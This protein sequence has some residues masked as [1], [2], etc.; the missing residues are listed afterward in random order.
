MFW[1]RQL[2]IRSVFLNRDCFCFDGHILVMEIRAYLSEERLYVSHIFLQVLPTIRQKDSD[3]VE[4]QYL[5]TPS[6][7]LFEDSDETFAKLKSFAGTLQPFEKKINYTFKN[8]AYLLQAF[9]HAS[10]FYNDI[11]GSTILIHID[12]I[13]MVLNVFLIILWF[14]QIV[15]SGSNFLATPFW[16]F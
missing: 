3:K 10:Y 8:K 1:S 9:T 6:N 7:V 14:P 2:R 13:P 5:S 15:I 4:Y 12:D 11:T 16:I